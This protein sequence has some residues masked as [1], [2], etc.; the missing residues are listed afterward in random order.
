MGPTSILTLYPLKTKAVDFAAPTMLHCHLGQRGHNPN[1]TFFSQRP[2]TQKFSNLQ[3]SPFLNDAVFWGK[4]GKP[5]ALEKVITKLS[6][7]LH[8]LPGCQWNHFC[9]F[10]LSFFRILYGC[11]NFWSWYLIMYNCS[12]FVSILFFF[13]LDTFFFFLLVIKLINFTKLF[14]RSL[15]NI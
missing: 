6:S 13:L 15:V 7:Y 14:K 11:F 10:W 4:R 2:R 3:N 5:A 12:L 9:Y 8:F 1:L